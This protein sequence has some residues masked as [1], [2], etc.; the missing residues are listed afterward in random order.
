MSVK[1]GKKDKFGMNSPPMN[2]FIPIDE[3]IVEEE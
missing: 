1:H 3:V 2:K